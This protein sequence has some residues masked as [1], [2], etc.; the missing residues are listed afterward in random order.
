MVDGYVRIFEH[1][2]SGRG[3]WTREAVR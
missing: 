1:A 2:R 3:E